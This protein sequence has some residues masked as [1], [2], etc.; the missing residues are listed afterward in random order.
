[1]K[2]IDKNWSGFSDDIPARLS[3]DEKVTGQHL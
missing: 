1:M 3:A 2:D